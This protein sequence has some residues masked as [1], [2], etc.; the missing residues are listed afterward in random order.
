ME[1]LVIIAVIALEG[2]AKQF[3]TARA[4]VYQFMF[5]LYFPNH[6]GTRCALARKLIIIKTQQKRI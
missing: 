6:H 2:I 5:L 3:G 1:F 4:S